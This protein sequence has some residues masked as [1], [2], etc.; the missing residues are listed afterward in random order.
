MCARGRSTTEMHRQGSK[1][2]LK[3]EDR[4]QRDPKKEVLEIVSKET[5]SCCLLPAVFGKT[6]YSIHSL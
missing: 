2:A 5:V 3:P 6:A 1:E 4:L